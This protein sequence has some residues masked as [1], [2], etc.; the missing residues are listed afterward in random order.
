MARIPRFRTL[1]EAA[2]FWDTHDLEDYVD[3]T[4]PVTLT[5]ALRHRKKV[6]TVALPLELYER[7]EA[8]AARRGLRLEKMIVEWLKEK[9]LQESAGK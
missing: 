9:S 4:E 7:I 6:L 2:E 3:D 5:V 8:L 1:E